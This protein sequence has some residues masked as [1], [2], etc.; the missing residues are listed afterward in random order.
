[1]RVVLIS[2][3]HPS[4]T[5]G[6]G[7]GTY[8]MTIGP[9]LAGRG[10]D[11]EVLTEGPGEEHVEHGVHVVPLEH[12]SLPP[13][14]ASRLLT[15]RQVAHAARRDGAEVVQAAEWE[16]EAWWIARTGGSPLVTRLATPTYLVDMLNLGAQRDQ[17]DLVRRMERDQALRSQAIVAPSASIADRVAADWRLDRARIDVI[18]N[19]IDGAAVRSAGAADPPVSLPPRYLLF[20]GRIERRKGVDVLAAALPK[21]LAAHPELHAVFLGRDAGAAGG[22]AGRRLDDLLEAFPGRVHRPGA[23]P[24]E[25]ALPVVARAS[26]VVLPSLWEAF[27][28][29]A[30]EAMALGRPV[31]ASSGSGF[32]E[33]IEH[34][35]SGWLV[36]PGDAPALAEALVERAGDAVELDRISRGARVRADD[37][38]ASRIAPMLERVYERAIERADSPG[39]FTDAIYSRGYRRFFRPEDS[40]NP[41]RQIYDEKL[42]AVVGRLR[43]MPSMRILDVGCGPGRALAPLALRHQM[44][45]CDVSAEMLEEARRRCPSHVELV[46]AD[47]R[48]LPFADESFDAVI[49]LDLLTHLPDLRAGVRELARVARSG[50]PVIFDTSNAEPWWVLAYPRYVNWRP[51]RLI[52]TM[53]RGG[54]LPEWSEIVRHHRADEARAAIEDAGLAIEDVGTFGPR[55]TPKWHLWYTR[56]GLP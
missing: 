51:R 11:V 20:I 27:G 45:G 56:K 47:A 7:I 8:T 42:E 1:M 23:L 24:R 29:V 17:S 4:R 36:P 10:H 55:W 19:P 49:A 2:R 22:D 53:R 12:P 40:G 9:A 5:S 50:G 6:G 21:A 43:A 52:A 18:P 31:I 35:R 16:A 37:F 46:R 15:A 13:R 34:D 38:E 39:H 44:T 14:T 41:F 26:L 32:E 33:I 30:V 25:Q 48:S 54:V 3:E 28:F